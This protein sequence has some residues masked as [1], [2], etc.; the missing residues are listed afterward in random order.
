MLHHPLT[1]MLSSSPPILSDAQVAD[2]LH[3]H[4]GRAGPLRRLTSERDLNIHLTTAQG[5]FVLKI[6]NVAEPAAV[7]DFQTQALLHLA[8]SD[9]P[10]PRVVCTRHGATQ[11]TT[12]HG[13][14]RLLTY[15][16]GVPLYTTAKTDAQTAAIARM[17][18]NLALGL[19]G[20]A[21]AAVDHVLQWDIKQATSLRPLLPSIADA[22]IRDLAERTLDR[23]DADVAPQIRDM[24]RQ[25]VHNDLNP[26][27][28]LVNL[29]DPADVVG[30]LDFGDMVRTP[31]ICDVA[32]AAAYQ[33]NPTAGLHSLS[34]FAAAYHA[35]LPLTA[36]EAAL[37]PDLMATRMLTTLAIT[38]ARA[39]CYPTNA[40]YILRNYAAARDGLVA[41]AALNRA[42]CA[43]AMEQL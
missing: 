12:P 25:V 29:H 18:A 10:T 14:V 35:V 2:I 7:T 20:F 3:E 36:P 23:F 34:N 13:T 40:A 1:G 6:A 4:Y 42:D 38:S 19:Q 11:V 22:A 24:R 8:Q 30:I 37:L 16:A 9:L 28:I 33:F 41:L 26:Y 27:N 43:R 39:A 5:S 32:I 31:L 21:H 15:L 17:A